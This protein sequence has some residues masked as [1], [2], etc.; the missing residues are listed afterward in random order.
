MIAAATNAVHASLAHTVEA[1]RNGLCASLLFL[2]VLV[3]LAFAATAAW[4][5][6][7]D[8]W[9]RMRGKG[10]KAALAAAALIAVLYGGSKPTASVSWDEYF[11]NRS[12]TIDTNDLRRISFT[13]SAPSWLPETANA[14][15]HA[16]NLTSGVR[17]FPDGIVTN[18]P[19]SAGAMTAYMTSEATNYAYFVECDWSPTPSVVTNGVYLIP[20]VRDE[21]RYIPVGVSVEVQSP[22][23][24][25]E[26]EWLGNSGGAY[27]DTGVKCSQIQGVRTRYM[28]TSW[29]SYGT[30]FNCY[31]NEQSNAARII[32]QST[33]N[34]QGWA[35]LNT[36]AGGSLP[37]PLVLNTWYDFIAAVDSGVFA[38]SVNGQQYSISYVNGNANTKNVT[39]FGTLNARVSSFALYGPD[40]AALVDLIPVRK[41]GVGY[42]YDLVSGRLLGNAHTTGRLVTP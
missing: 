16:V 32:A 1:M 11:S 5:V 20:A 26:V 23:Y 40:G 18:A 2:L 25:A 14:V 30:L 15:L 6:L 41:D 21:R 3:A 22:P 37:V 24:D 42:M 29:S 33:N 12:Y 31:I 4:P 7:R 19:M 9:R 35:T 8:A 10:C 34:G 39:L 13:W 38:A 28:V 36:R 27:I 17:D